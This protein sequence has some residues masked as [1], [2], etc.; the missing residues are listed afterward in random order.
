M[1]RPFLTCCRSS[2]VKERIMVTFREVNRKGAVRIIF[3]MSPTL[4]QKYTFCPKNSKEV[5]PES[6]FWTKL[7][8]EDSVS[9]F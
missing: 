7:Q 8:S 4:G 5:L 9:H 3:K 2:S 6:T 1:E